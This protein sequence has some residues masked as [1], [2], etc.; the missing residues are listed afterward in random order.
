MKNEAIFMQG[1]GQ[2]YIRSAEDTSENYVIGIGDHN[3]L[4]YLERMHSQGR[5]SMARYNDRKISV[6]RAIRIRKMAKLVTPLIENKPGKPLEV[7]VDT[8]LSGNP[9]YSTEPHMGWEVEALR[10]FR[11]SQDT[12]GESA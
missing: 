8:I 4:A 9:I 11:E 3:A 1:K 5:I 2:R 10:K 7:V 6:G 12:Y